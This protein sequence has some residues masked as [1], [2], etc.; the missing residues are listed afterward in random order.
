MIKKLLSVCLVAVSAVAAAQEY[1]NRAIRLIVPFPPGG[2]TDLVGRQLAQR[3]ST[4]LGQSVVADNR[5][6]AYG[7][8]G[9]QAAA[10]AAPDGY[11]L[12][13]GASSV[14]AFNPIV[15][16]KIPYD[17]LKSFAPVTMLTK[18]PLLV[19]VNLNVPVNTLQ[20]LIALARS[21]P[22]QL[23]FAGVGTSVSMPVLQLAS[24]AGIK[25]QEV[26]YA[27]GGPG[28]TALLGGQ[29]EMMAFTFG[30]IYPQVQAKKIRGI[31]VTSAKRM[32]SA[33][34]IPTV[35][36]SGFPGFEASAW[37]G[38]VAP[39]GTPQP[40]IDRLHRAT[41]AVMAQPDLKELFA[42]QGIEIHTTT[43]AEFERFTRD[44]LARWQKVAKEAG[45][46]PQ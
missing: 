44:E 31:A 37:N 40:I 1:P 30:T 38:L 26:P 42:K 9:A 25:I 33:P 46:K 23:N 5:G 20:E 43:P 8:V 12:L 11:T 41:V 19:A 10:Q 7:V 32:P 13:L 35:A 15:Y 24:L 18:Q 36:E 29:V 14:M 17:P 34:D 3:L 39:A 6:G 45:I 2:S 27:G 22:G 28:L 16:A 21:K 4:E